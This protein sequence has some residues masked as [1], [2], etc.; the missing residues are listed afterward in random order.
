V[1]LNFKMEVKKK[2]TRKHFIQLARYLKLLN[3]QGNDVIKIY[4]E[5]YENDCKKNPRFNE[6][7]FFQA[8]GINS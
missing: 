1:E 8:C 2:L 6:E 3:C 5:C 4:K 7:K